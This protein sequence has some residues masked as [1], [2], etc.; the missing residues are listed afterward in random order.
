MANAMPTGPLPPGPAPSIPVPPPPPTIANPGPSPSPN[1]SPSPSP[2]GPTAPTGGG[3]TIPATTLP[4]APS[5]CTVKNL[6]DVE[7]DTNKTVKGSFRSCLEI[8]S[9]YPPITDLD[10]TFVID[11]EI[12]DTTD[13]KSFNI[14][15]VKP[16]SAV[17]ALGKTIKPRLIINGSTQDPWDEWDQDIPKITLDGSNIDSD[18]PELIYFQ[19]GIHSAHI[20]GI[21]FKE[22]GLQLAKPEILLEN[23]HVVETDGDCIEVVEEAT[24]ATITGCVIRKCKGD[25]IDSS[26]L[27][28]TV[29]STIVNENSGFG[30]QIKKDGIS[31]TIGGE[32]GRVY[33]YANQKGGIQVEAPLITVSNTFIGMDENGKGKWNGEH[34][35]ALLPTAINATIGEIDKQ[36]TKDVT[37]LIV[38]SCQNGINSLAPNTLIMNTYIG[39]GFDGK[40]LSNNIDG[41]SLGA[42]AISTVIGHRDARNVIS[43]N[44]GNGIYIEATDVVVVN[45][46][47]GVSP[48]G[49]KA[50]GNQ[51]HG[52]SITSS[53][54]D[55]VVGGDS[56]KDR[57]I[58]S[59]NGYVFEEFEEEQPPPPPGGAPKF[60]GFGSEPGAILS[61]C[62]ETESQVTGACVLDEALSRW[63]YDLGLFVQGAFAT[64]VNNHIGT[65]AEGTKGLGNAHGGIHVTPTG[66]EVTITDNL[67]SGNE[68]TGVR[69]DSARPV[70]KGNYIGV[71][72]DGEKNISNY[73]YGLFIPELAVNA[74]VDDNVI[75]GNRRLGVRLDGLVSGSVKS[76]ED[77]TVYGSKGGPLANGWDRKDSRCFT[78]I[79]ES[80]GL[81]HFE[82]NLPLDDDGDGELT[83]DNIDFES[84]YGVD[85]PE[86]DDDVAAIH[87]V[88]VGLLVCDW[89]AIP[90]TVE[91]IDF[92]EN[93]RMNSIPPG[94]YTKTT[95]PMLRNLKLTETVLDTMEED[96]FQG[97]R[98]SLQSLVLWDPQGEIAQ[99]T[100]INLSG[101]P[102]LRAVLYHRDVCP[103][104][105][106][107]SSPA[108][109]TA[110]AAVC[111]RCPEGTQLLDPPKYASKDDC[112]PC[113][114]NFYDHDSDASTECVPR[115]PFEIVAFKRDN[116]AGTTLLDPE[117]TLAVDRTYRFGELTIVN[118]TGNVS[119]EFLFQLRGAPKTFL[120]SS[121]FGI[122]QATPTKAEVFNMSVY[123]V[124]AAGST[125]IVQQSLVTVKPS[126]VDLAASSGPNG[127]DCENGQRTSGNEFD[128][129]FECKC[130]DGYTGSNC[131]TRV[132][133]TS[134]WIG[135]AF[136]AFV[137]LLIVFLIVRSRVARYQAMKPTNFE[138]EIERLLETGEMQRDSGEFTKIPREI[139][140]GNLQM[141]ERVGGGQF[142][143]VWKALL[144]EASEGGPPEYLVAAK[145]VKD[146]RESPEATQ[147]LISEAAL[148]A[149]VDHPNLVSIVGVIT[150][151]DPLVLVVSFC[152]HGSLLSYLKKRRAEDDSISVSAKLRLCTEVVAGMEYL[153]K[154]HYVHRDL[155]ARNV[156]V[157]TGLQAKVAD[158]G[159]SRG[160][161]MSEDVDSDNSQY[162]RSQRG[163]FPVRWTAPEAM[164]TLKFSSGTDVWSFG[165]VMVEVF[166]DG[167]IPY[168]NWT[169]EEIIHKTMSG[170]RCPKPAGCSDEIYEIMTACWDANADRR[171]TFSDLHVQLSKVRV[172]SIEKHNQQQPTAAQR[173]TMVSRNEPSV[174]E[175]T[176]TAFPTMHSRPGA[177]GASAS[178]NTIDTQR[179]TLYEY[180]DP[181]QQ[182]DQDADVLLYSFNEAK[183]Q[184]QE[185]NKDYG[186]ESD[187]EEFPAGFGFDTNDY[188][189]NSE[190]FPNDYRGL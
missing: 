71:D 64:I 76:F 44:K 13:Q 122:I 49:K 175:Y 186:L 103:A 128:G 58:V 110:T 8:Y 107:D 45:S 118:A 43:Y 28:L 90:R 104:G 96:D 3:P 29:L 190:A 62:P 1:P 22:L 182:V 92:T 173:Q 41:I 48:D 167:D 33:I 97:I 73:H 158:F 108:L 144:N 81:K 123:A 34:G 112:E 57:N 164:E 116:E 145:V 95:F 114:E 17:V 181:R 25:G 151:G 161:T 36:E 30:I 14:P 109:T 156:L 7:T 35:I 187:E 60:G 178:V 56:S 59:G 52:I 46:Y 140:R 113:P 61:T 101:A 39:I 177:Y 99:P 136:A 111:I 5:R 152:E 51:Y 94:G 155:A 23:V 189:R 139:K 80:D 32:G 6:D 10:A 166:Q 37:N 16:L 67:I 124:D 129:Q 119:S 141:I 162:Y 146:S 131:Q 55:V 79:S 150:R 179:S 126:D 65:N 77:N 120:M 169:N 70:V 72:I 180:Q 105:F 127:A 183:P 9:D 137:V 142:G 121:E 31:T 53:A 66:E 185:P 154:K 91:T 20:E 188:S 63:E 100:H 172:T 84:G 26:A 184:P 143:E 54:V 157:A 83:H 117:M 88:E 68:G 171:P 130:D 163:I 133:D 135:I 93:K 160:V 149:Q 153:S 125:A 24:F 78:F 86:I 168:G 74:V 147:E 138:D 47:V 132:L 159:L 87:I 165:I 19:I 106:Y 15:L 102:N 174:Y 50:A 170:L 42:G 4:S 11:F 2:A 40:P 115:S 38:L 82:C 134:V 75:G 69:I 98:E 85:F 148:M 176:E 18:N 12:E 21:A 89:D 27:G